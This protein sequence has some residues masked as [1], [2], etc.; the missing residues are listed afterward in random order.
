[1]KISNESTTSKRPQRAKVNGVRSV[2]NVTGKDPD[3]VYRVVNDVGDRVALMQ[4][5]G[6]EPVTDPTIKIGERR[7]V[8]PTQQGTVVSAS[9]GG[10]IKGVLMRT[11]KEF[12][13]ED[14]QAK[15]TEINRT[16]GAMVAKA[17]EG[18]NGKLELS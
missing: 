11:P 3:Y 7:I 15:Q 16:E 13:D 4:E 6:Y 5:R 1:M 8:N 14:Q 17:K 18:Y 9:V 10:G 2:L 12:F